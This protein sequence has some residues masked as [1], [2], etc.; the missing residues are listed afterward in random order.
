MSFFSVYFYTHLQDE[1]K[2]KMLKKKG[3]DFFQQEKDGFTQTTMEETVQQES[4]NIWRSFEEKINE[5]M[6][7]HENTRIPTQ[8]VNLPLGSS[9][10][11]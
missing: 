8:T 10:Q 2:R 3:N 7:I 6:K 1:G 5:I 11:K 9:R 4:R